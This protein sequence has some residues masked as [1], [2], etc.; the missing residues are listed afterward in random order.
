MRLHKQRARAGYLEAAFLHRRAADDLADRLEAVRR[1]FASVLVMGSAALFRDALAERP[2]LAERLGPIIEADLVQG[3]V[4]ID[5][6][7][8]PFAPGSFD[9]IV[10]P[11][12]LHWANDLPG[13]LLRLRAALKPDGLMLANLIG[14]ESLRE[15]R[16]ALIEAESEIRGGA[17]ARV[18]PFVE[19]PDLAGLVQGAGFALPAA[20]R[21]SFIVRYANLFGLLRD[22]RAMGETSALQERGPALT[23]DVIAR[24][25]Q[26]YAARFADPDG[27]I[28]ANFEFLCATGWAPHENQ[29]KPLKPGSAQ[30]RLADALGVKER[31]L[32]EGG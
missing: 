30:T 27:R 7:A 21:V 9:L 26:I 5:L 19:L 6:E 29:Q 15:L 13:A 12:L 14:G 20:D 17:A 16:F 4:I 25:A 11:L 10:S 31:P 32:N 18:S 23:R 1:E 3:D 24:A 22:L 8:L 2:Q 28:R